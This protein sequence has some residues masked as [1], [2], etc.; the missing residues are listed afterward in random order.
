MPPDRRA[1]AITG[2][3]VVSP[4]GHDLDGFWRRIV[5]G[6]TAVGPIR[7]I[8]TDRLTCS[9][10]AEIGDFDPASHFARRQ[11]T[12]L[13]RF[14]QF[15][16][17]AARSAVADAGLDLE[18]EDRTA[19][20][21][22]LGTGVGG[23]TTLEANYRAIYAEDAARVHP[24]TV[25]RL[26]VNAAASQ[27]S[28][29]LGLRGECYA[30]ASACASGTHAI[31]QALRLIRSGEASTALTGGA[32]ACL[33][34]AT[35]KGWE[36]LRVMS[37]DLCRPF[38]RGRRGM[39]LG[40]GAA[41]LVLEDLDHAR[42]RGARIHALL[43]GFGA[44]ADAGDLTSPSAEGAA[45]AMRRAL[46]DAALCAGDVDYVNAHGTGTAIN[47]ASETRAIRLAFGADAD[48]LMVS[49][50]KAVIG[51]ALGAAGALEAVVTALALEHG[52]VPPTACWQEADPDCDL[53]VVPNEARDVSVRAALSNSFAFGGLNGVLALARA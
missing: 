49:S 28:M 27:V 24:L 14:A 29:D 30:V 32:E 8:P 48:R 21:V 20:P 26:M 15:A 52:V 31:G 46:R 12:M 1:V 23:Q 17:V 40:E 18:R 4:A 16:V 19:I 10:A 25:P 33:T 38:S 13:D 41:V 37:D 44:N 42:A 22:I 43:I 39:V 45:G 51:H 7:N 47:D 50:S 5:A 9:R 6:E 34:M 11:L 2:M 36:A 35:L 53:D 3:G